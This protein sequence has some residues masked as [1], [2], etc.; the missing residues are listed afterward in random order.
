VIPPAGRLAAVLVVR[1]AVL[2]P[3]CPL[4]GPEL[5]ALARRGLTLVVFDDVDTIWAAR[6]AGV[7]GLAAAWGDCAGVEVSARRRVDRGAGRVLYS[8]RG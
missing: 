2:S 8:R 1:E 6:E 7:R 3:D 4:T 5:T